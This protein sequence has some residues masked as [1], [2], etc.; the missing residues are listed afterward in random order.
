MLRTMNPSSVSVMAHR[1]PLQDF[2]IVTRPIQKAA[3]SLRPPP[4]KVENNGILPRS[5][6]YAVVTQTI[7][8]L[9]EL[10]FFSPSAVIVVAN[11]LIWFAWQVIDTS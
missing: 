6:E 11:A 8:Y 10:S 1:S 4:G 5:I 7:T 9:S 2:G 3:L